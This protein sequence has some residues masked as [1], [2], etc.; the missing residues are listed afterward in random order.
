MAAIRNLDYRGAPP[1][2]TVSTCPRENI[3]G[4]SDNMVLL[5]ELRALR[6]V[7]PH[8]ALHACCILLSENGFTAA[9]EL[10]GCRIEDLAGIDVWSNE[11]RAY[12]SAVLAAAATRCVATPSTQATEHPCHR[13]VL[14]QDRHRQRCPSQREDEANYRL[15]WKQPLRRAGSPVPCSSHVACLTTGC[16][17]AETAGQETTIWH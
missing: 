16:S 12:L 9:S 4:V 5:D 1:C 3:S 17:R 10:A 6:A 8:H 11:S 7:I 14:C 2:K 13:G 15:P